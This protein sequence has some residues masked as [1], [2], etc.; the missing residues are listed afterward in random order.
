M[1]C[2][3]LKLMS[4]F[5]FVMVIVVFVGSEMVMIINVDVLIYVGEVVEVFN[6]NCVQCYCLGQIVLMLFQFYD[7]VCFWVCLI[8]RNVVDCVMFLWYV[9]D[10]VGVF[11]NDCSFVQFEIDMIVNWVQVGVLVGDFVQVLEVLIFFE[12]EWKFGEFDKIVIFD[13]I[14]VKVG[15]CDEFYDFVGKFFLLEDKWFIGIE[16]LFGN[17]KVVYYVIIYEMKGFD[18][19]LM[20]GWFGVWVV[21]V[22]LM[23]FFE[24]IG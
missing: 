11:V 3:Y 6:I 1:I 15:D 12:G 22:E 7:E 5:V 10:G 18:F 21:G 13:E 19:D 23:V 14:E 8:V 16:I 4:F 17:F 20:E 9:V 2:K 24:G